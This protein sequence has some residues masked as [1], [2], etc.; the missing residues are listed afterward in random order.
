M[1]ATLPRKWL[2]KQADLVAAKELAEQL[3]LHPLVAR[4]LTTRNCSRVESAEAFLNADRTALLDPFLMHDMGRAV[5]RIRQAV[6]AGERIRV[7][8]DYDVD[9]VTSTTLMVRTLRQLGANVDWYVPS[10]F[11]DGYGLNPTIVEN[12]ARDGI[13][14]IVTVDN[15][16]AAF[17]AAARAKELGLDVIVTDHHHIGDIPNVYA[18]VHPAFPKT[19]YTFHDLCG[20]GVAFKV[21]Q[22]LL[23]RFPEEYLDLVALGTVA[24]QMPLIGENRVL[25]KEGLVQINREQT[26]PGIAALIEV[27]GLVGKPI[28]SDN[29]AFQLAPRVNAV[30]RLATADVAVDLMLA[31]AKSLASQ[32]AGELDLYNN[33]RKAL[34]N[35]VE[36]QALQ[37]I[38][39]HPEWLEQRGLVV[40]G[41][42][43]HEGVIGIVAGHLTERFHQ[44]TLCLSLNGDHVKGSGRAIP[45]FDLYR[46]LADVQ[47]T[48]GIFT[49]WG[50]HEAAAGMSLFAE[51]V[52][53]LRTAYCEA[54]E[55]NWFEDV[56]LE[57]FVDCDA[58]LDLSELSYR[59]VDDVRLLGPFGQGNPE[60]V[61]FIRD[62]QVVR[63]QTMGKNNQHLKIWV[64]DGIGRMYPVLAFGHGDQVQDWE[65][66]LRRHLL[67]TVGDNHWNGERMLQLRLVDAK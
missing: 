56:E 27:A 25:V 3:D 61:F 64:R 67:V 52:D 59:L 45:N 63:V 19:M 23:G 62:A 50:G 65:N 26:C 47:H 2:G 42:N 48:T 4:V 37:Q 44:S 35:E 6:Q 14:L 51:D 33:R 28:T 55:Q 60:P 21:A 8:G 58:P 29:L 9:G 11:T 30:G 36:Q 10:R 41:E 5:H 57:P 66:V 46:T 7:V 43:W 34:Q 16:I 22:A 18:I 49:K 31:D 13:H 1:I 38:E 24:D 17:G 12:A 20:A 40:A 32:L 54:V 15:G 39:E 53:R